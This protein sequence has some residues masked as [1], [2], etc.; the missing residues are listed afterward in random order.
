M[1]QICAFAVAQTLRFQFR[2]VFL[3]LKTLPS[4]KIP[5][6][7]FKPNVVL[8]YCMSPIIML[9]SKNV[10]LKLYQ[11]REFREGRGF[12]VRNARSTR[13]TRGVYGITECTENAEDAEKTASSCFFAKNKL[14]P[15]KDGLSP[16][17]SP[18]IPFTPRI[19][20]FRKP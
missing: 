14:Y 3:E 10:N 8:S 17:S 18:R 7:Y 19:P 20:R 11:N 6:I 13:K 5:D 2:F 16:H 12:G 9:V 1:Y 4:S 15:N